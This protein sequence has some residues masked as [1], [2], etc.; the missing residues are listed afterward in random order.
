MQ[1]MNSAG[2]GGAVL[3]GPAQYPAAGKQGLISEMQ[4][5]QYQ[6]DRYASTDDVAEHVEDL[7]IASISAQLHYFLCDRRRTCMV[8]EFVNGK[9]V[10]HKD[11][12]LPVRALTN[13]AYKWALAAWDQFIQSGG[14]ETQLPTSYASLDRF[15]RAAWYQ[16]SID[17][18]SQ[19]M[20]TQLTDLRG[21]GWTKWQTV[22]DL[23]Q[24]TAL[25]RLAPAERALTFNFNAMFHACNQP[26]KMQILRTGD[27]GVWF[28]YNPAIAQLVFLDAAH[29]SADFPA[30][31]VERMIAYPNTHQCLGPQ[32]NSRK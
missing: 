11:A 4:W 18:S 10:I 26:V 16:Q 2:L 13:S 9:A 31:L 27:R 21:K 8:V 28:D 29:D 19:Q 6:L 17:P 20:M 7:G 15:V 24:N 1:G 12:S 5:L 32:T 25:V 30:E 3:V 14:D 22:F 23:E